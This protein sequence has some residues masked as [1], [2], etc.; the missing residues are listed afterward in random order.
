M[1]LMQNFLC[2]PV[3]KRRLEMAQEWF[4]VIFYL[5][6]LCLFIVAKVGIY[7]L[8]DMDSSDYSIDNFWTY[9]FS[10]FE[11]GWSHIIRFFDFI[12]TEYFN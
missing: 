2:Q 6:L 7:F 12:T 10:N 11:V 8:I 1:T 9:F 3:V 4:E 5:S